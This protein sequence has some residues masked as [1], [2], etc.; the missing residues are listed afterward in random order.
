MV[1]PVDNPLAL[2]L[3]LRAHCVK[4]RFPQ[5]VAGQIDLPRPLGYFPARRVQLAD[6]TDP[7][8]NRKYGFLFQTGTERSSIHAT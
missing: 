3:Q 5:W 8:L 2:Y 1:K 7:S 6:F 4:I